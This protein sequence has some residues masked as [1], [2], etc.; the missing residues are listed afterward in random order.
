MTILLTGGTGDT[1]SHIARILHGRGI[2]FLVASRRGQSG[3]S[4]PYTGVQFDWD[5]ATTFHYPFETDLAKESPI[6]AVYLV[7]QIGNTSVLEKMRPFIDLAFKEKGV[8]RFVLL[9]SSQVTKGGPY[10]GE[11]HTYFEEIGVEYAVLR[12]SWFFSE[13]L[14]TSYY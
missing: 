1:G 14:L 5:D 6:T 7:C 2:P 12:P 4:Q 10:Y 9:S 8:K 3:V 11:V 13:Y